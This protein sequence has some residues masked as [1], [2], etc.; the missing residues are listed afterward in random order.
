MPGPGYFFLPWEASPSPT[1]MY[2]VGYPQ[3]WQDVEKQVQ[4]SHP[5][6]TFIQKEGELLHPRSSVKVPSFL[7]TELPC[8]VPMGI[9]IL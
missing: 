6:I 2:V 9:A 7:L 1:D 5:H 3:T 4:A 8:S